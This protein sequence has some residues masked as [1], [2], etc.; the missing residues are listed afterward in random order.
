MPDTSEP[1]TSLSIARHALQFILR[2]AL[3]AEPKRC[4]GLIGHK[5]SST[6]THTASLPE[7]GTGECANEI[8]KNS[9]L[10]HTLEKWTADQITPCGIF[11]TCKNGEIPDYSAIAALEKSLL[12]S[13]PELTKSPVIY[14]PLMLNTAGCLE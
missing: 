7:I 1:V 3:D 4:I 12:N 14:M 6:I 9:D 10:Q 13:I 8:F 11:F 2:L 5:N